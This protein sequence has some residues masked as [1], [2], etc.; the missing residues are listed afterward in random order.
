MGHK[1]LK[2]KESFLVAS[3]GA[4]ATADPCAA[5]DLRGPNCRGIWG[6][7]TFLSCFQV[8][9]CEPEPLTKR[10]ADEGLKKW[11][12][13]SINSDVINK[14]LDNYPLDTNYLDTEKR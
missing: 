11:K 13:E 3:G 14:A 6:V 9:A 2:S 7:Q 4:I 8:G 1:R 12:E 5:R 10:L